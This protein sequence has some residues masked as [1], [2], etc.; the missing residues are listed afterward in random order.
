M[1]LFP[2]DSVQKTFKAFEQN[3]TYYSEL[4]SAIIFFFNLKYY[5]INLELNRILITEFVSDTFWHFLSI[6]KKLLSVF[7]SDCNE[8]LPIYSVYMQITSTFI[9]LFCNLMIC[10]ENHIILSWIYIY[11]LYSFPLFRF[12]FTVFSWN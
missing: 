12:R 9:M 6:I 10:E 7:P 4:F 8:P 1:S 11:F 3:Y 2:T 5:K